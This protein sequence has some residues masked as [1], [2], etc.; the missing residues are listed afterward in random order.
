M[1]SF[2]VR[3]LQVKEMS[4]RSHFPWHILAAAISTDLPLFLLPCGKELSC[5]ISLL[6]GGVLTGSFYQQPGC[7]GPLF[8]YS[9]AEEGMAH[10]SALTLTPA[11]MKGGT[12][13]ICLPCPLIDLYVGISYLLKH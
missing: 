7:Q 4:R 3:W 10:L 12:A 5:Q 13:R 8:G 6:R 1:L 11:S 2:H 9:L